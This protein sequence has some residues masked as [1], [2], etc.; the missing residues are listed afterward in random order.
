MNNAADSNHSTRSIASIAAEMKQEFKEFVETRVAMLRAEF[1]EKLAHW[2]IAAPLAGVGAVLLCTAYFLI[3]LSLVALAAVFIHSE[4]RWFFALLGV[5]VLWA[6]LAGV[7]L[8]IAKREFELNRV[9]PQKTIEVLK[10]DK[11]W[12]QQEVRNQ[13]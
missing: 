13:I 1:R 6:I 12:L 2:K 8:Y 9:M 5:G 7:A 3:T 10:G 4:Y 11:V